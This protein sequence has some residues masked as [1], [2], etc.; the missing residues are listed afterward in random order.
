[1]FGLFDAANDRLA[2]NLKSAL[3]QG[4]RQLKRQRYIY[5]LMESAKPEQD[6]RITIVVSFKGDS[7]ATIV[8][9]PNDARP[10][11]IYARDNIDVRAPLHDRVE[12]CW[13]LRRYD[14]RY[15]RPDDR[16]LL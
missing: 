13:N 11:S 4:F 6:V 3:A 12:R 9:G 16:R 10:T 14:G 7:H 15:I 1:M 8:G 5:N 2:R